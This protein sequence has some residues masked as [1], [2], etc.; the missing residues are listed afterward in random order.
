MRR[1]GSRVRP[2]WAVALLCVVAL[3]GCK[4]Q[5]P[6][7]V[8]DA[9]P[10]AG[11]A[12]AAAPAAKDAGT[13]LLTDTRRPFRFK[14]VTIT[15]TGGSVKLAYT[16]EN[17]GAKRARASSCLSLHDKDGYQLSYSILGPISLRGGESDGFEDVTS[18]AED[19]WGEVRTVRLYAGSACYSLTGDTVLSPVSH[20]DLTGRPAPEEAP[21]WLKLT[22]PEDGVAVFELKDVGLSQES[23]SDSV[24]VTF[25][26][27]NTGTARLASS[28]CLRLYDSAES[29]GDIDEASS[30]NF[31]LAP[32]ATK[33]VSSELTLDDDKNWDSTVLLRAYASTYGC[34]SS[35]RTAVS[36]VVEFRKPSEIRSPMDDTLADGDGEGGGDGYVPD[37]PLEDSEPERAPDGV[38]DG[39]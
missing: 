27:T 30:S 3:G 21:E 23:P 17:V 29:T 28:V 6:A 8:E 33:T 39:Q 4:K 5:E 25:T 24:V 10:D 11:L 2:G 14:D 20:L 26:V 12:A 13:V 36:N 19:V 31:T 35:A 9:T 18:I 1:Q 32:G 37:E 7:P 38:S 34:A 16:L 22:D 15:R